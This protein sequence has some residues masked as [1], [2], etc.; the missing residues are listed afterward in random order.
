MELNFKTYKI[1]IDD[2]RTKGKVLNLEQLI[3]NK[4]Y[5]PQAVAT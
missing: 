5:Q 1:F 2:R 3:K 4:P